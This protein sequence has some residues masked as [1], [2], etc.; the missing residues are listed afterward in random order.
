MK[1]T[2]VMKSYA[3]P[4]F[5]GF[6][7][8]G[9]PRSSHSGGCIGVLAGDGDKHPCL[10]LNE[11]GY[12]DILYIYIYDI[13]ICIIIYNIHSE[14]ITAAPKKF[15]WICR[16]SMPDFGQAPFF[17]ELPRWSVSFEML[18]TGDQTWCK[19]MVQVRTSPEVKMLHA[20]DTSSYKIRQYT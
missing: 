1:A 3:K 15:W 11:S 17:P 20:L 9:L 19:C 7:C 10:L 16:I 12:W 5:S 2:S 13:C 4:P 18:E 8:A 14:Q 6:L